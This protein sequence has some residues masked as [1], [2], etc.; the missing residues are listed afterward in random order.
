MFRSRLAISS[1]DY[2]SC[3]ITKRIPVRVSILAV[4]GTE[5]MAVYQALDNNENSLEQYVKEMEQSE[6]IVD[7]KVTQKSSTDYWTRVQH[8]LDYP[9]IYETILESGSMTILPIIIE[10]GVQYH[11]ILSPTPDSLR[12]LLV[13]LKKR[14]S[15]IK[16]KS[17]SSELTELT[18]NI[19]NFL[20]EKQ[21]EVIIIT[22]K[23]GY[24]DIPRKSTLAELSNKIGIKRV[25]FQERLK[26]AE[27][28][29]IEH[30]MENYQ[31]NY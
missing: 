5:G 10:N 20:T 19:S 31:L 12:H 7:I 2:Y 15:S 18:A 8:K 14:F 27:K 30:Y 24:Y 25:A 23:N 4:N 26:R 17:L 22:Y 6:Q 3:E 28:R 13:K 1:K 9:S 16:I 29:I 11:D 21:L